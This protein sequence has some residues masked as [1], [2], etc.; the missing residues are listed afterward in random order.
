MIKQILCIA[1]LLVGFTNAVGTYTLHTTT[2]TAAGEPKTIELTTAA[3]TATAAYYKLTFKYTM[4]ASISITNGQKD[5]LVCCVTAVAASTDPLAS[6]YL[7]RCFASQL[8]CT[9]ASAA[10]TAAANQSDL[11][12]SLVAGVKHTDGKFYSSVTVKAA[13]ALASG[14]V[15]TAV[16]TVPALDLQRPIVAAIGLDD[17]VISDY[18]LSCVSTVASASV[19]DPTT[20]NYNYAIPTA[21]ATGVVLTSATVAKAGTYT[22]STT[23]AS[24][25]GAFDQVLASFGVIAALVALLSFE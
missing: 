25:S 21:A 23:S 2:T 14:D 15:A 18:T 13:T 19:T 22:C 12:H 6:S 8:A 20:A 9:N 17:A 5:L 7:N 24:K 4:G 3:S 1:L 10:C 11:K 16:V